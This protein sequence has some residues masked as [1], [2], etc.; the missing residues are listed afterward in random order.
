MLNKLQ[1][2]MMGRYGTDMLNTALSIFGCILS[3]ILPLFHVRYLSLLSWIPFIIVIFRMLSKNI[4]ARQ[5]E[6]MKFM[7]IVNPWYQYFLK[8]LRQKQDK[9]HRYYDCPKCRKTLRVPKGK[10]KINI[11]CPHCSTQFTKKT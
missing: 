9:D 7:K 5:K 10:G 11:R 2:F 1:K 6:N 8:K 3:F 4:P